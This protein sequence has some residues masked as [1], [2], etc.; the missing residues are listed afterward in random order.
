[1]KQNFKKNVCRKTNQKVF[2]NNGADTE[3][4]KALKIYLQN[5]KVKNFCL[6]GFYL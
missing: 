2:A 6:S 5:N 1:M 4:E 3:L